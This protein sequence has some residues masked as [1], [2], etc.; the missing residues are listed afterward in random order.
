[1]KEF[2]REFFGLCMKKFQ[3]LIDEHGFRKK[4]KVAEAGDYRI[5]FQNKTTAVRVG[6]EWRDQYLYVDVCRLV[7]GKF[8]E[9][10]VFITLES[11]LTCFKLDDLLSIRARELTVPYSFKALSGKDIEHT[12]TTYAEGLRLHAGDIL[13][14]DFSIFAELGRIVKDRVRSGDPYE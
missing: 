12:L 14:G 7:D 11:E 8:K 1:M 10:P 4:N 2:E 6:L 13:Q 9:N 3:F 5:L